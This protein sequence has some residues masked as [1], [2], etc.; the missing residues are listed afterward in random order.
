MA[1]GAIRIPFETV[2]SSNIAGYGYDADR[3][4]LAVQFKSGSIYHYAPFPLE[5]ALAFGL[6]ESKGKHYS[7]HIRGKVPG[8]RMTGPCP[9][10]GHEG[11]IGDLCVDCGDAHYQ[12]K[13][14]AA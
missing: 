8:E 10:C 3:Q 1:T 6:A 5:A 9:A 14:R 11:W 12:A 2:E 4:I 7:T 13:E